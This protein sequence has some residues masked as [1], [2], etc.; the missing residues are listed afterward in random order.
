MREEFQKLSFE[1]KKKKVITIVS[2]L[3]PSATT[4][5][6]LELLSSEYVSENY[7]DTIYKTVMKSL[8]DSYEANKEKSRT[9]MEEGLSKLTQLYEKQREQDIKDADEILSQI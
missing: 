7:V 4:E 8:S 5:K 9:E 6:T 3:T 1:D 2:S